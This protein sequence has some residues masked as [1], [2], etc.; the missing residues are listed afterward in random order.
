M[1][2]SCKTSNSSLSLTGRSSVRRLVGLYSESQSHKSVARFSTCSA[3][4]M[5]LRSRS[6][7]NAMSLRLAGLRGLLFWRLFDGN[8]SNQGE[9]VLLHALR[10]LVA[11]LDHEVVLVARGITQ[12]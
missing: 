6:S 1:R 4:R 2:R 10:V 8:R 5:M 7:G 3:R 12:R 9:R 11:G